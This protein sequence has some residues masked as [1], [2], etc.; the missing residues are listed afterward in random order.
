MNSKHLVHL[1]RIRDGLLSVKQRGFT[2][3]IVIGSNPE[4]NTIDRE[5]TKAMETSIQLEVDLDSARRAF[6]LPENA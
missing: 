2:S 6:N 1:G 3:R 4:V 5:M